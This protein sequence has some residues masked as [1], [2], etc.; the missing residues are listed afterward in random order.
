M[1]RLKIWLAL[2][3]I[4]LLAGAAGLLAMPQGPGRVPLQAIKSLALRLGLE[5]RGGSQ[6]VYE[7]DLTQA[8]ADQKQEALQ[9]A[10][11]VIERRVNAF[12]VSEPVVQ[13]Q[14]EQRIIVELPGV[15]DVNK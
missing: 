4:L 2:L 1:T 14:G 9:G 5:L 10:R 8:Q 7:A 13:I 15:T 12:G 3:G 6:L 11:D